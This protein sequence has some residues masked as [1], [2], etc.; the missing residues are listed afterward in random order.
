LGLVP[1]APAEQDGSERLRAAEWKL[2]SG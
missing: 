1:L 2:R